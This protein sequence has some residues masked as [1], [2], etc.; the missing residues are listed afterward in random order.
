MLCD[1][2]CLFDYGFS[3]D[4]GVGCIL[5]FGLS[6]IQGEENWISKNNLQDACPHP[7]E[8]AVGKDTKFEGLRVVL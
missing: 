3:V 6:R 4:V 7:A 5:R 8:L 2:F 1:G